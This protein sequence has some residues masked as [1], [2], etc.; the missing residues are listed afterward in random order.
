MATKIQEK[1][2]KVDRGQGTG[3][4]LPTPVPYLL[5]TTAGY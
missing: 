3:A 2:G 5:D 4:C 1:R